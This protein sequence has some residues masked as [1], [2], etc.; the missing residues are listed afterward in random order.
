MANVK[1]RDLA[2]T[3]NIT[4]DNKL[5]ILTDENSNQVKN[6]TVENFIDNINSSDSDNGITI[7]TDGKLYVDN[8]DSGVTPGTYQYVKNLKVNA[9]GKITSIEEGEATPLATAST[10]GIVQPDGNSITVDSDGI[11]SA[12]LSTS[13]TPGIVQPDGNTITVDDNG[14]ISASLSTSNSPG[15]VQPDGNTIVVD[16]R[17]KIS[18]PNK[19]DLLYN[20]YDINI[21]QQ[22]NFRNL[23][24]PPVPTGSTYT[25]SHMV[26][27]NNKFF[28]Y[29]PSG[30][31]TYST[32]NGQ[33]WETP[34]QD[35]NLASIATTDDWNSVTYGNGL[36]VQLS[37]KGYCSTSTDGIE[38]TLPISIG[39]GG[40]SDYPADSIVY[41]GSNF[42]AFRLYDY[43][44]TRSSYVGKSTDGINWTVNPVSNIIWKGSERNIRIPVIYGDNKFVA[45]GEY[46]SVYIS[47]DAINWTKPTGEP[48]LGRNKWIQLLY[49]EGKFIAINALKG[50]SY[51]TNCEIWS[52]I[53]TAFVTSNYLSENYGFS[54]AACSDMHLIGYFG[55]D[56]LRI[57]NKFE[58]T[59]NN[60][61]TYYNNVRDI[62]VEVTPTT[63]DEIYDVRNEF[64]K[65]NYIYLAILSGWGYTGTTSGNRASVVITSDL[66]VSVSLM[67]ATTRSSSNVQFR[68][69]AVIPVG[70]RRTLTV[71]GVTNPNGAYT[72]TLIGYI[73]LCTDVIGYIPTT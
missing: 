45:I 15:I 6:I 16:N 49:Y 55:E 14:I 20:G 7:G 42:V 35:E 46:G 70:T 67:G 53:S 52:P 29:T 32:D 37:D 12:L 27:A 60:A 33:T 3:Q 40:S 73:R 47:T 36:F 48:S 2:T 21:D 61:L 69:C 10:P 54:C 17:G 18:V 38:W 13:S 72:L 64:P 41:D 19:Q 26:Y 71:K 24:D 56:G 31:I 62:A 63:T 59:L 66:G 1:V 68:G 30:Y 43:Y 11:I 5:M 44:T 57:T 51:S 65:D 22:L 50:I 39:I 58:S 23:P 8:S 25:Y 28:M 34:V 9:Q 4:N